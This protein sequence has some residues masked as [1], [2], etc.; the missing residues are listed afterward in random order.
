MREDNMATSRREFLKV[1]GG[2]A[3]AG[4]IG[5]PAVARAQARA[6][7]PAGPVKIGVLAIRAGIAAPVGTAGLRGTEWWADRVN[8]AGGILG[9]PVQLVIEE[10]SNPKDTVERYRKLVLQDKVE[11][12]AGG[13]STGVTLALGPVAEDLATPWLSWDGTTQ[14]GVEETMPSPKWAFKSVDNE[15]EAIAGGML[16][17][18]YFKGVKTIAGIN[19]D[20]SYGHDCWETYLAVL[21]KY[22]MDPKPVV[23]LF[24]KLGVT[25]FTSHIAAIQQAKP[26]LL[27]TSFWSGDA[28]ILMKQAAAVG[29]FK[30]MKGVFTTAGGVHD[31]LKKEFTPEGLLLGYNSMY[32]DDPK[33]SA[34]L[35]Q[36][37]REYKAKYNEYP[38]YECDHA[39]FCAESFK[40]AVE[41]V[42][43]STKQWPTKEQLVKALEG[44]EA[45]SLSGKRSWRQDHIQMCNFYQGI[46]T[47]KNSYD[48]VTINPIEVVS[49]KTAMKPAGSKLLEW[50]NG[51]KV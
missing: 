35:K 18:K 48:F 27:M 38:P 20:Y 31:S 12:V 22:G 50:I 29:L 14:K 13:I 9:R 40:A 16:T 15:V 24:P 36:F 6:G 43:N 47:H 30:Q 8:K 49:T 1:A 10:E 26:D 4:A 51:W 45:E 23:E 37:V 32:F 21:R 42:Y 7:V 28:T 41:K 19:N 25:D 44:I 5:F 3:A 33:G 39:Y 46:T 2:A 11:V 17:A 34:L